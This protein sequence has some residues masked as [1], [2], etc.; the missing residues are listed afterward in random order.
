MTTSPSL[1]ES[2][3]DDSLD[4]FALEILFEDKKASNQDNSISQANSW[5]SVDPMPPLKLQN[6]LDN[7]ERKI[8]VEGVMKIIFNNRQWPH[9]KYYQFG[10]FPNVRG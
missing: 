3:S 1:L 7:F 8:L 10:N 2:Y 4:E 9:Y 6:N 5:Y